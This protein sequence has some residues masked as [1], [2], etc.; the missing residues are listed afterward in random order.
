MF[1]FEAT[2]QFRS[3]PDHVY[4]FATE[5]ATARSYVYKTCLI[6][7]NEAVCAV[8]FTQYNVLYWKNGSLPLFPLFPTLRPPIK[9]QLNS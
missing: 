6:F 3:R 8:G 1:F 7:N 9:I 5:F 2:N 4:E